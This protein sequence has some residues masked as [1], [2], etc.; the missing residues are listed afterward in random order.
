MFRV[1]CMHGLESNILEFQAKLI[2]VFRDRF[3]LS[4]LYK[5][6]ALLKT[7]HYDAIIG[8]EL[9]QIQAFL[10]NTPAVAVTQFFLLTLAIM[11]SG[12][13]GIIISC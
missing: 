8:L 6:N 11:N 9:L 4:T 2:R 1:L 7:N 10:V 13:S 12:L 3:S 5:V